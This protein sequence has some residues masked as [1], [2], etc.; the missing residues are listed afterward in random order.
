MTFIDWLKSWRR[1][2][3]TFPPA[4]SIREQMAAA[5]EQLMVTCQQ[6]DLVALDAAT[7]EATAQRW[8]HLDDSA[9]ALTRRLD[10]L[11]TALRDAEDRE[12][13]DR[14]RE[15]EARLTQALAAYQAVTAEAQSFA[16]AAIANLPDDEILNL[17][18]TLEKKLGGDAARL[19]HE[20]LD[21]VALRRPFSPLSAIVDAMKLRVERVERNRFHKDAPIRLDRRRDDAVAQAIERVGKV[22]VKGAAS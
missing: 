16:D 19:R 2:P 13:A 22:D 18:L 12:A 4:G 14:M 3:V 21:D 9:R 17:A 5:Q 6:R 7:D 8:T 20:G 11:A 10:M 15:E 1:G